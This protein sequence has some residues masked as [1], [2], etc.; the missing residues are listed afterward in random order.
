MAVATASNGAADSPLNC[1]AEKALNVT[2]NHRC[3]GGW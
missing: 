2:E 3:N 1:C